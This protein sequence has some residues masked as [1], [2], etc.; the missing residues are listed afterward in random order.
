MKNTDIDWSI[1]PPDAT[2]FAPETDVL[3]P[4]FAKQSNGQWLVITLRMID[5]GSTVWRQA[6][7]LDNYSRY[8]ARPVSAGGAQ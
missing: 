4:A 6:S 7:S 5:L 1:A 3:N 2:H 8:I